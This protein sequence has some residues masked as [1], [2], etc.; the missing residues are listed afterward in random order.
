MDKQLSIPTNFVL[1]IF[2][3]SL[4][5]ITAANFSIIYRPSRFNSSRLVPY[6]DLRSEIENWWEN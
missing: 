2:A 3:F 5:K 4:Y 1:N 6:L